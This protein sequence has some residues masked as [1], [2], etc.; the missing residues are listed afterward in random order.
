ME[1]SRDDIPSDK[2]VPH[3]TDERFIK[4][5]ITNYLDI[6]DIEPVP[7]QIALLHSS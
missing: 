2:I 4:L 1:I 5:P 6:L 3:P 7:P